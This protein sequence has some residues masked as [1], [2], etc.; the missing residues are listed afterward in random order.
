MGVLLP[1]SAGC[2]CVSKIP[3]SGEMKKYLP[4]GDLDMNMPESSFKN[5]GASLPHAK[6]FRQDFHLTN[7]VD[8]NLSSSRYG[9]VSSRSIE[10]TGYNGETLVGANS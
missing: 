8:M 1:V 5:G 3:P 4:I 10:E 2:V 6:D 9:I 7:P